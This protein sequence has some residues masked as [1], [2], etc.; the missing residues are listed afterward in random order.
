MARVAKKLAQKDQQKAIKSRKPKPRSARA[1]GTVRAGTASEKQLLKDWQTSANM[2]LKRKFSSV[3]QAVAALI[4]TTLTESGLA[5]P[6][7][8]KELESL[9]REDSGLMHELELLLLAS[10]K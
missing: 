7:L 9:I 6:K 2:L 8:R 3:D 4:D 1:S 5:D 10:T